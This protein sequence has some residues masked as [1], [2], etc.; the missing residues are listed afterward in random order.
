MLKNLIGAVWRNTPAR[1]RRWSVR[2]IEPR[3]TVTAGA[4]VY[5]ERGRVLLLKHVFRMGSGWGI[6]GGFV[7]RGEQTDDALRRELR[8]E[9]GLEVDEVKIAFTRT[10]RR[11]QQIEIIYCCRA[12]S[13][14]APQSFEIKTAEWFTLDTLPPGLPS[15]QRQ[16]IRRVLEEQRSRAN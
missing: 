1:I 15:D 13:A 11:P 4:V 10:S 7:E 6:P 3:F 2:A 8:E 5:D 14:P 12:A 9:A 16:I